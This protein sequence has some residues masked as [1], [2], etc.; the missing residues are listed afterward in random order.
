MLSVTDAG[1]FITSR[2]CSISAK[3]PRSL[4]YGEAL[5]SQL[6]T[7]KLGVDFYCFEIF[8]QIGFGD[9]D[10]AILFIEA[11]GGEEIAH[12]AQKN[13]RNTMGS[14]VLLRQAQQRCR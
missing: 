7:V 12:G 13:F 9:L 3:K 11:M 5:S 1:T 4:D 2:A 10:K 6:A 14:T 8:G